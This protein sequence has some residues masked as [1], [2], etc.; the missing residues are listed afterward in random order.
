M[1]SEGWRS[2]S[3]PVA[4]ARHEADTAIPALWGRGFHHGGY[5]VQAARSGITVAERLEG[6]RVGV[7]VKRLTTGGVVRGIPSVSAMVL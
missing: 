3:V 4:R 1:C 6:R 2:S 7:R 5:P